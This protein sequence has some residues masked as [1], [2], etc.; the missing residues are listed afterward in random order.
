MQFY[1]RRVK[2]K[3]SEISSWGCIVVPEREYHKNKIEIREWVDRNTTDFWGS[4]WNT[5][6][7]KSEKD[8]TIFMLRWL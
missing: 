1:E 6:H 5:Y 2:L 4:Y 8:A 3:D 7:F